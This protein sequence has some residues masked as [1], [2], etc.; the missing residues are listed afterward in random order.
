MFTTSATYQIC[1][2]DLKAKQNLFSLVMLLFSCL[3][4]SGL[5]SDT[6]CYVSEKEARVDHG[7]FPQQFHY[8]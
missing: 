8:L 2:R 7:E 6:V 4:F 1:D 3:F 5:G